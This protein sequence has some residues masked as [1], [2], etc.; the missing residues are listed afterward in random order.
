MQLSASLLGQSVKIGRRQAH[1]LLGKG[2]RPLVATVNRHDTIKWRAVT[3]GTVIFCTPSKT[4][5]GMM[6]SARQGSHK[7][8][9]LG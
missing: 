1:T 6:I 8:A 3:F 7:A 5:G 2:F 9:V 4:A